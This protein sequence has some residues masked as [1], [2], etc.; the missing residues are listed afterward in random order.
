MRLPTG[1]EGVYCETRSRDK[2]IGTYVGSEQ[3]SI[4]T[5]NYTLTLSAHS[6]AVKL[7]MTNI[8]NIGTPPYVATCVMA[9]KDSF[10]FSGSDGMVSFSGTGRLVVSTLTVRYTITDGVTSNTC[11]YTGS[12]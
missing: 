6:E 7:T 5:D 10:T 2:F 9:A 11:V 12:K 4:G 1:Y 3:C 8:Y